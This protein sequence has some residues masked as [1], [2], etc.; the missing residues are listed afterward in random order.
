MTNYLIRVRPNNRFSEG[1]KA[2]AA[3]LGGKRTLL[4]KRLKNPQDTV[5]INW[6]NGTRPSRAENIAVK[7]WL[8]TA[9]PIRMASCKLRTFLRLADVKVPTPDYS[10]EKEDA[11]TRLSN[12][13]WK[14]AFCR[15]VLN[16]SSG[17]GIV[18]AKT[19][20]EL[21][22]A[23][24]YVQYIPKSREFRVHVM[25][26]KV[27]FVQEKRKRNG[28]EANEQIRSHDNGWVFCF[29]D[30]VLPTNEGELAIAAVSALGLDFG[31]VDVIYSKKQHKSYVLEVNTAP[32]LCETSAKLY[33]EAIKG[34]Q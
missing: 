33:A 20:E 25:K 34:E 4:E 6:G 21:V 5:V 8:N 14:S 30:V 29:K 9:S 19:V 31:A 11:V 27:I 26:G 2:L 17:R 3:A 23:P 15:T 22:D 28:V 24:L 18:H 1:A 10:T 13:E 12:G 32:G 7:D 16:G